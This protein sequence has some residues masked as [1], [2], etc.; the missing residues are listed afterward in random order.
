[1]ILNEKY[2]YINDMPMS[3]PELDAHV[4]AKY[5]SANVNAIHHY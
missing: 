3:Q 4:I 5:G 1:M 2:D